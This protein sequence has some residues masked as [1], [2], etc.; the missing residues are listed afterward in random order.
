MKDEMDLGTALSVA[1]QLKNH[2][3][4]FEHLDGFVRKTVA[5]E[6]TLREFETRKNS[7]QKEI[8][9]LQEK[10]AKLPEMAARHDTLERDIAQLEQK[11]ATMATVESDCARLEGER[12]DL[13]KAVKELK[14]EL[15]ELKTRMTGSLKKIK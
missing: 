2:Y 12:V 10:K 1:K 14:G 7:L 15:Q 8:T 13:E 6:G 4:V 9:M 5:L 11:K 3:R